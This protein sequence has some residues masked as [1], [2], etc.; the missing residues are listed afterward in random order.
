MTTCRFSKRVIGLD[1]ASRKVEPQ[2]LYCVTDLAPGEIEGLER[3]PTLPTIKR[4]TAYV[5]RRN[6]ATDMS[7][8]EWAETMIKELYSGGVN[9]NSTSL[10]SIHV[11]RGCT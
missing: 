3:N 7:S 11:D 10:H 4:L 2:I 9:L 6:A 8:R 5:F 1:E